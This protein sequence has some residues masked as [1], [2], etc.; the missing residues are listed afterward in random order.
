[1]YGIRKD[2]DQ[3]KKSGDHGTKDPEQA[4]KIITDLKNGNVF[5]HTPGR[6]GYYSFKNTSDPFCVFGTNFSFKSLLL[7]LPAML[8]SIYVSRKTVLRKQVS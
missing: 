7:A 4:V 1:M 8:L 3:K 2:L 5:H 6:C